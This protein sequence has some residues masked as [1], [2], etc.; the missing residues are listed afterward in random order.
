MAQAQPAQE[1]ARAHTPRVAEGKRA[2]VRELVRL[3]DEAAVVAVANIQGIPA[4]SMGQVRRSL[5]GEAHIKV[6]KNTLLAIAL[7][8]AGARKPG[9]EGLAGHIAGPTALLTT[10][11]NPFRLYRKLER[12]K[13]RAPARGGEVAPE[14]IWVHKGET[15]FKPGP[16]VGELQ[17][18]GIPAAI[19]GGAVVIKQDKL[20]V[21]KGEKIPQAIA[22]AL[23]RLE[24]FPL[25]VGLDLRAAWEAGLLYVPDVLRIDEA[26]VLG[27]M[28]QAARAALNLSVNAAFPTRATLH[29]M[30]QKAHRDALALAV[31][32]GIAEPKAIELLLAKADAAAL[33]VARRL[34]PE[35]LDEA[36]QKRL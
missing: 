13:A 34:Q 14:D 32:R 7:K 18:S 3:L 8:E 22:Q 19:D 2:E 31:E 15:P 23:T 12:S 1:A 24:V 27:D 25:V 26:R 16:I 33:A 5:R 17:R 30:L 10:G 28:A 29:L 9:L 21:P 11:M 35:A 4:T 36:V 20:L 6:A